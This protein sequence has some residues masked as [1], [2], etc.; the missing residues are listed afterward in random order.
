MRRDI[1]KTNLAKIDTNT[2]LLPGLFPRAVVGG[3]LARDF[4]LLEILQGQFQLAQGNEESREVVFL[5]SDT[6]AMRAVFNRKGRLVALYAMP[7]MTEAMLAAIRE[8]IRVELVDTPGVEI[9][10]EI[11]FSLAP[12][13][14]W[15][16]YRDYFQMLPVPPHAPRPQFSHAEHPFLLEFTYNRSNDPLMDVAHRHREARPIY[17]VLR[18]MLTTPVW[19][20][21]GRVVGTSGRSWV[22]LPSTTNPPEGNVDYLQHSY[23]YKGYMP[24]SEV[25][26][27]V[28]GIPPIAA[29]PAAEYYGNPSRRAGDAGDALVIPENLGQSFDLFFQ[30]SPR[31]RLQFLRACYWLSQLNQLTSFSLMFICAV[32]AIDA[33]LPPAPSGVCCENCGLEQRPSRTELFSKFL[34]EFAPSPAVA[35]DDRKA[36]FKVRSNLSHGFQDPFIVDQVVGFGPHL[37]DFAERRQ[38]ERAWQVARIALYNWLHTPEQTS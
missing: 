5:N 8:R 4:D 9:G 14:G 18:A 3:G 31:R 2:D 29:I 19:W 30:A 17:L 36:L 1:P 23:W 37:G 34:N 20:E 27:P 28:D 11:F 15:W 7:G 22:H 6:P 10:R 16:R 26:S 24:K 32:Q 21:G 35:D 33:L 25:F 12:V 13:Q 38:V